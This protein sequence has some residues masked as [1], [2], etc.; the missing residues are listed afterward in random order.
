MKLTKSIAPEENKN[1]NFKEIKEKKTHLE[2][3]PVEL[4]IELT[5]RCNINPPC[6]FCVDRYQGK[7]YDPQ[8]N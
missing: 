4:N 5:G 6:V 7:K 3:A 1:L 8:L 2:S